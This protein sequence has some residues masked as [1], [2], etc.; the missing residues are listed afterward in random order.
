MTTG[1]PSAGGGV[2]R[3]SYVT[4]FASLDDYE[5]GRVELI[6]DD[7]RHYAFSNIFDVASR[8]KPWEKVAVGKNMEYVLEAVRA[9]GT[10]EWRTCAHDE[11]AVCLDGEVTVEL[12]KL[13][14][15]PLPADAEGSVALAGEPQ[16]PRMGRIFLKRGHQALLPAGSAYRFIATQTGV[17]MM[18]TIAGPD[19]QF[20]W[21]E[22]CQTV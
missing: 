12:V 13:D 15:S 8:S 17:L 4:R 19:T 18:Q 3:S 9:E 11:F 1:K 6:N 22:I 20:R 7:P 16:G 10:S 21:A 2:E 5:K 14:S